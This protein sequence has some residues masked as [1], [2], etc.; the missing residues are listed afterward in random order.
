MN[1]EFNEETREKITYTWDE[2]EEVLNY[3]H[4]LDY[5]K[6]VKNRF[7]LIRLLESAMSYIEPYVDIEILS[8]RQQNNSPR[9]FTTVKTLFLLL[10]S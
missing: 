9:L 1:E 8:R 4:T 10:S 6:L 5:D 2:L 3:L 7:K